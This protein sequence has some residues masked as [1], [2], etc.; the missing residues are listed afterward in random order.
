MLY[1]AL[2]GLPPGKTTP[3]PQTGPVWKTHSFRPETFTTARAAVFI[4]GDP[5]AAVISTRARRYGQPHFENCGAGDRSPETTDIYRE[6]A[7]NYERMFDAWMQPQRFAMACVRYERLHENAAELGAF[8]GVSLKLPE[9]RPR[10]DHVEMVTPEDHAAI[11][12]TY[13]GLIDKVARA[14]DL[15]LWRARG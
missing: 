14:P 13:A 2:A 10:A 3:Q 4:Y 6:D 11:L 1:R 7:L 12:R 8:L 9:K 5:V 15:G